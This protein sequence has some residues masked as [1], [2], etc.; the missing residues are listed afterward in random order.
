VT[1]LP[2]PAA[3]RIR[4]IDAARA[5]AILGMSTVHFGPFEP[6]TTTLSGQLYRL[7]YGRASI[8]FV[9]LAGVG[10]SLLFA[11]RP[12]R[13]GWARIG[14]RATVFFPLGVAL[15]AL[16]TPV[17]VILQFYALYY[18]V[19]AAAAMLP[20]RALL[21]VTAAWTAAG[22]IAFLTLA[23]PSLVGRGTATTV[24]DPPTVLADLLLTG[25]Y[26][27]IT[28]A[29]PLLV[30]VLVGRADLR[31]TA[32]TAAL[33]AAGAVTAVVAY[34]GGALARGA[35][36]ADVAGSSLLVSEGHSGAPLNVL[37]ATG[38]AVAVLGLCLLACR[39]A[40]RT[41]WPVV[42]V[43]QLALTVY[44]GHLLVL[45]IAPALLE[46][47]ADVGEAWVKVGRFFLV[48]TLL[49]VGWRAVA[50]RGPLEWLLALPFRARP[51]GPP[52]PTGPAVPLPTGD[53]AWD[54]PP[55]PR[56]P[57]TGGPSST[58]LPRPSPP[59]TATSWSPPGTPL[60]RP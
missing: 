3:D 37:G 44:V 38:V 2:R 35:L 39:A 45:A 56:T 10:I 27:L 22:P 15:Q 9:L 40:P 23:D 14:W 46:A 21:A 30:G 48:T 28:W 17:A 34:G 49:C 47:R 52:R 33:A 13:A 7:S 31:R 57:P 59:S 24:S 26:P 1:D 20:T 4:G 41:T 53:R 16:P 32:T 19:G 42:A 36:P 43:G 25:F 50:P 5:L 18:V 55:P 51:G 6:D 29:P 54:R 12:G 60:P 58:P 8:L 11:A